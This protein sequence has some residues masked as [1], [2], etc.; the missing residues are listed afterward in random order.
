MSEQ[1]NKDLIE[2]GY[3][4]FTAGDVETVMGLF[5]DDIEWVQPGQSAIS[6]TYHGRT[7]VMEY[8][9]R[10]AEKG[11]TVRLKR[12][13][14]EGDTVVAIT[15]VSVGGKPARTPT[16]SPSVTARR[17]APNCTVTP[18][19]WSGSTARRCSPLDD[20]IRSRAAGVIN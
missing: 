17:C 1:E 9:G 12:L 18:H 7:E 15:E 11:L 16:Y 4:A 10:L 6:G 14:A 5:D 3:A 20:S 19:C 2:K 8:M 13:I